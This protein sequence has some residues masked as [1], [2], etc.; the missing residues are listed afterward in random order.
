MAAQV[1]RDHMIFGGETVS[2]PV[3]ASGMITYAMLE[4][5]DGRT[6]LTP[7]DEMSPRVTEINEQ[8]PGLVNGAHR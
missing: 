6:R 2:D 1:G 5:E 3:P 4:Q 7:F 8:G